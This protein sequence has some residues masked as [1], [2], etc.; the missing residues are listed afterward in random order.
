[1]SAIVRAFVVWLLLLAG[2]MVAFVVFT[3]WARPDAIWLDVEP[4]IMGGVL[5]SWF[6]IQFGRAAAKRLRERAA[7]GRADDVER[8]RDGEYVV[9]RG[10]LKTTMPLTTPFSGRSAVAYVYKAWRRERSGPSQ[11]NTWEIAHW[12][13]E[14]SAPCT[15]VTARASLEVRSRLELDAWHSAIENDDTA[16]SNFAAYMQGVTPVVGKAG[17]ARPG[18]E[19]DLPLDGVLRRDRLRQ[20]DPPPLGDLTL[21]ECAVAPDEPVVLIGR[22]SAARGGLVHDDKAG[23]PL[24][25]LKGDA[26]AVQSGLMKGALVYGSLAMACLAGAAAFAA[27]LAGVVQP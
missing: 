20:P 7:V 22:Y 3:R 2:C 25:A 24:R 1:M 6:G 9:A 14:G 26:A 23:R 16:R 15:L 13:G 11:K 12:W 4:T 5:A 8:P 19:W 21:H 17:I 10:V 27:V 18:F